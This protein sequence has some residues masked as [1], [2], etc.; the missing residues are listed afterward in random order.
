[1]LKGVVAVLTLPCRQLISKC[2]RMHVFVF[3]V[4]FPISATTIV[5]HKM[6]ENQDAD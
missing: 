5:D 2:I 1:M 3:A 6:E 4:K